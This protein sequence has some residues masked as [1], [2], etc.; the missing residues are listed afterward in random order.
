MILA[1]L[2]VR[3]TS[4][5]LPGKAMALLRGEPMVWRQ[6]ERIRQAR[7][8]DRVV[9]ATSDEPVDDLLASF[10]VSRGVTVFRGASTNLTE[11]FM[12]CVDAAGPVTGVVRLKGDSPFVDPRIIDAAIRLAQETGAAYA[13][14]RVERSFPKGLEVEVAAAGALWDSARLVDPVTAATVSPMAQLRARPDR[15]PHAHLMAARD[16]S[17]LD[18]RIKTKA[19]WDFA[20]AVYDALYAAD[21][22]FSME[23]VLDV[24]HGRQAISSWVA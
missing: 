22:A 23:D 19:D 20:R 18:W 1:I 6:L 17:A 5:R 7:L 8:V 21:P 11:R 3:M 10:L 4:L 16:W 13:S 14:N 9:V 15:Y 12:R 2:Q 24:L